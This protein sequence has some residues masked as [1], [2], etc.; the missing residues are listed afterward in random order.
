V[1][2]AKIRYVAL[3]PPPN[4]QMSSS[5]AADSWFDIN[6]LRGSVTDQ[7]K[8]IVRFLSRLNISSILLLRYN[9]KG[10]EYTIKAQDALVIFTL[11]L[12][13]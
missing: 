7:T 4:S 12:F 3:H 13:S 1:T 5:S 2:G 11:S 6:E 8:M 9:P 10:G